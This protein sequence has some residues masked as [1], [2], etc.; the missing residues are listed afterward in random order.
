M[1]EGLSSDSELATKNCKIR[2]VNQPFRCNSCFKYKCEMEEL[3]EELITMKKIIQLLEEELNTYKG[4]TSARTSNDRSTSHVSSNPINDWEVVTDKSRKSNRTTVEQLPIPVTPIT[5]CFNALHNLQ[6][7]LELPSNIQNHHIKN[8]HMKKNIFLKHN[9]AISSPVR[10][11]T[12]ILL[13]GDSHTHGCASELKKYLSPKYEVTGTIMPGSRIQNITK[14]AKNE[15]A[16]FSN[17]EAVIIWGGSNDINRNEKMKGL[18]Y[19]NDFVN[20]RKNTNV[21]I[22]T[23]PHRHGL[24]ITS[25]INN[26]VQ[27]FNRKLHKIM[28]NKDN[29]RILNLETIREDFTQHGLHLNAAGKIKVVKL[30]SQKISQLFEAKKKHSIILKW[31]ATHKDSSLINSIPKVISEDHVCSH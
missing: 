23:A 24:L 28:K 8:H 14:L 3:T 29:V 7:D 9:K 21:M 31:V 19:L 1:T 13:I 10:R 26:E 18:K 25:C 12:K 27:I 16:R 30:M 22:V 2:D 15:T 11:K 17:T 4:L 5:K 20:Q 6:N